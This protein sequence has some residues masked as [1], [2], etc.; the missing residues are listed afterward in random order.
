MTAIVIRIEVE[1]A[2][3][4]EEPN[5]AVGTI[6]AQV[7]QRLRSEAPITEVEPDWKLMDANGNTVGTVTA[8]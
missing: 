3:F 4:D 2:A 6:L 7:F 1:N 5:Q 8:E